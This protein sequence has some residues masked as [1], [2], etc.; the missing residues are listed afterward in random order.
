MSD[1]PLNAL[2]PAAV[3]LEPA[4]PAPEAAVP[5]KERKRPLH[6]VLL[7]WSARLVAVAMVAGAVYGE[8]RT[9]YLESFLVA[10]VAKPATYSIGIG[11][12]EA[13]QVP[14]A[15]PY[16]DRLG[17]SHLGAYMD[18]L[19][20]HHFVIERQARLSPELAKLSSIAGYPVYREK[21]Q[22]GVSLLDRTGAPL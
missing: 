12:S 19:T 11:S 14:P 20:A 21:S 16:D 8:A 17:Y 10:R 18:A 1:I 3:G 4:A 7:L 6:L 9:S 2:H 5:P 13:L 22:A 15:S